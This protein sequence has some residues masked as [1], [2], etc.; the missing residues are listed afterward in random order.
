MGWLHVRQLTGGK[1][2]IG[3]IEKRQV[4]LGLAQVSD[5]LLQD[6]EG[7][8]VS[9]SS[10]QMSLPCPR[11]HQHST[12]TCHCS[13]VGSMPVGLCAQPAAAAGD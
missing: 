4:A 11:S 5:G 10:H 9:V 6:D 3:N 8:S 1:A 2:L 7:C 13:G 12:R